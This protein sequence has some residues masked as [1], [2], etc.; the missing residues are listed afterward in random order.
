M[1]VAIDDGNHADVLT[2]GLIENAEEFSF[3]LGA[4]VHPR[5]E[6]GYGLL[7]AVGDEDFA[8]KAL[9]IRNIR[10]RVCIDAVQ[11]V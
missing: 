10:F 9:L 1:D 11:Q 7:L 6:S 2:D 5:I 8:L 3:S 4:A